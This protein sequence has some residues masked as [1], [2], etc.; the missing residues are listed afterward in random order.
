[1]SEFDTPP[2]FAH[3]RAA[4]LRL[5]GHAV[6]TPLLESDLLNRRLGVRLLVKAECL[7]RTGS[8]KFRGAYNRLSQLTDSERQ[9]G[10]VAFSSGNH[11]QGVALAAS[12]LGIRATIVMPSDAPAIKRA[13]TREYGAEIIEYDRWTEDRETVANNVVADRGGVIVKPF[14]DREIIAGQGTVALEAVEQADAIGVTLDGF[15]ACASG[16]GLAAGCAL[17]IKALSPATKIYCAE[18]ATLD[19]HARSLAAGTKLSNDPA[20]RSI[21]DALMAPKPGDVTFQINR[22]HLAGGLVATDD[23]VR[24]AMAVAFEEFKLVI[25]PGGAVALAAA[26]AGRM[27]HESGALVVV[28]SGGNVDPLLFIEALRA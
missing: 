8:F 4:A 13:K 25:E 21:C 20:A 17:A 1:V 26:L 16:G 6:R 12:L 24:H 23:E 15:A 9:T 2:E 28:A 14:D 3:V 27:P 10:V 19:D 22:T 11:A 7:Q 5:A 18:P